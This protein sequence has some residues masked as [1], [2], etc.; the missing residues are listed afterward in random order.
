M[1]RKFLGYMGLVLIVSIL[2]NCKEKSGSS[3]AAANAPLSAVVVF[4]VG[5]SKIV[6]KDATEEK[7]KLGVTLQEGDVLETFEKSKVDIQFPDGANLRIG[8]NSKI[9]LSKLAMN[10]AGNKE[11]QLQL[12]SGKVFA[13]VNKEKKDDS[14]SVVTPT[15]I[16]GVRGT[17]FVVESEAGKKSVVKVIDGKVAF[18]PSLKVNANE[19]NANEIILNQNEGTELNT[20]SVN[21]N[22]EKKVEAFLKNTKLKVENSVT[23]TDEEELSTINSVD[24]ETAAKLVN[25]NKELNSSSDTS[26]AKAVVDQL[27]QLESSFNKNVEEEKK[28]FTDGLA[29]NPKAFSSRK[30]VI[31]YYE[32]LEQIRF[33]NG[34][35]LIGAIVKQ[36]GKTLYVHTENGMQKINSEEI[37]EV[38]LDYMQKQK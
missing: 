35:T 9:D 14:F 29:S 1:N 20:A 23:K 16:A 11:T 6:H 15:A 28:K 31:N 4:S 10:N 37:D 5:E 22:D 17:S 26:K 12:V 24:K 2:A 18:Q 21:L 32:K 8:A 30:E 34:K 19:M 36:E 38:I 13:K 25:L 33:T 3:E 27:S 7:A